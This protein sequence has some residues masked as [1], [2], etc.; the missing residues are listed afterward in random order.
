MVRDYQANK[1]F[2][3][4]NFRSSAVHDEDGNEYKSAN[5]ASDSGDTVFEVR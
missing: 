4:F 1:P 3:K 2:E 5:E